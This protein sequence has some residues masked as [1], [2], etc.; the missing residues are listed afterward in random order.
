M[1]SK[2]KNIICFLQSQPTPY[3]LEHTSIPT[4][5][6]SQ[7]RERI[8]EVCCANW[9]ACSK[10]E[11]TRDPPSLH[12]LQNWTKIWTKVSRRETKLTYT[13]HRLPFVLFI[14]VLPNKNWKYLMLPNGCRELITGIN[15]HYAHSYSTKTSPRKTNLLK[16]KMLAPNK[17]RTLTFLSLYFSWLNLF[18]WQHCVSHELT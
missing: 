15:M 3:S 17:E 2:T 11:S 9:F 8:A 13:I 6:K 5:H 4:N 16:L 12:S 7:E 1:L 14:L 10:T 18:C